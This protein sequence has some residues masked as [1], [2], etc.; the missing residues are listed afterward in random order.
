[1]A[2]RKTP[3][4][5]V[6]AVRVIVPVPAATPVVPE[7]EAAQTFE[8]RYSDI[9]HW[10]EKRRRG[11][12]LAYMPWD[13]I[14]Q[15]ILI[16]VSQ[17][18]A[19]FDPAKGPFKRWVNRVITNAIRNIWRDEIGS[20][21]RPCITGKGGCAFNCGGDLCSKTPSGIQCAECPAFRDWEIR[22]KDH[23][24]VKM[25][26]SLE[27]HTNE[28]QSK[29][30]ASVDIAE[31]KPALDARMKQKLTRTEWRAYRLLYIKHLDEEEVARQMGFR[32]K[33]GAKGKMYAG[34]P[35]ILRWRHLFEAEAKK[36]LFTE[37]LT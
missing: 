5:G 4:V 7:V 3:A 15:M 37:D 20:V 10:V 1:M 22:K 21:S 27:N 2:A 6:E 25:P 33:R 35:E 28:A 14:R 9:V 31:M 30:G 24:A 29:V 12:D 18:Y 19:T 26:V 17:Q 16:R 32:K 13:E 8:Q 34:Y 11:I 23:H 36:I